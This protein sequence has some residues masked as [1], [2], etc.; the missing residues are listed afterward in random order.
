MR[1][2][3]TFTSISDRCLKR[4]HL[5]FV[6]NAAFCLTSLSFIRLSIVKDTDIICFAYR[7][8]R[9][10]KKF[11]SPEIKCNAVDASLEIESYRVILQILLSLKAVLRKK[12]WV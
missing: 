1:E 6:D 7:R 2:T 4:L 11:A 10:W 5:N 8:P 12:G 9:L 3:E